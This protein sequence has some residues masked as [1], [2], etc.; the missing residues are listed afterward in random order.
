MK[1]V[2]L[3]TICLGLTSCSSESPREKAKRYLGYVDTFY[4]SFTDEQEKKLEGIVDHYFDS[5]KDDLILNK[6]IYT[7]L[8]KGLSENQKLDMKYVEGLINQKLA[9]NKKIIPG[10]LKLINEFYETLTVEQKSELLKSLN[11]LKKKS[12]RMRY[13][14]GE[15][16]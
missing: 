13:W 9:L 1:K 15:E 12:A 14:L 16:K 8:E 10:Q 5:K 7:H 3:F 4:V 2:F 6:K 11:K